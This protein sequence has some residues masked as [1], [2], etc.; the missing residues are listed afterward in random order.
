MALL[1]LALLAGPVFGSTELSFSGFSGL[2]SEADLGEEKTFSLALDFREAESRLFHH[3]SCAA[4]VRC[5]Q[6]PEE[7]HLPYPLS[8]GGIVIPSITLDMVEASGHEFREV[9]GVVGVSRTSAFMENFPVISLNQPESDPSKV[10]LSTTEFHASGEHLRVLVTGNDWSFR[11]GFFL[12]DSPITESIQVVFDPSVDTLRVPHVLRPLFRVR[13]SE[14]YGTDWK[15]FPGDI[16]VPC[17]SAGEADIRFDMSLQPEGSSDRIRI[18]PELLAY[19]ADPQNNTSWLRRNVGGSVCRFRVEFSADIHDQIIIGRQ[20]IS[21]ADRVVLDASVPEIRFFKLTSDNRRGVLPNPVALIPVFSSPAVVVKQNPI[22]L[23]LDFNRVGLDP[24][25]NGSQLILGSTTPRPFENLR[26]TGFVYSFI[27]LG[28]SLIPAQSARVGTST[29]SLPI[30]PGLREDGKLWSFWLEPSA[31]EYAVILNESPEG[32]DIYLARNKARISM[33]ELDL[34]QPR[35]RAAAETAPPAAE[36]MEAETS[37][38]PVDVV[39][40]ICF[41]EIGMQQLVQDIR[42]CGHMF[43]FECIRHWLEFKKQ[44]C[45]YC[46][47]SVKARPPGSHKPA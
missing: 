13:L 19:E 7:D 8:L 30:A 3:G 10:I 37:P 25:I 15:A 31:N 34:P 1:L 36:P 46:R 12:N 27:R 21:A 40:A 33:A 18:A 16:F 41:E 9:T 22:R 24:R 14:I 5:V 28:P 42:P 29:F 38:A 35:L 17:T 23:S 43:H 6:P 26:Q 45:P 2:V 4:F 47:G 20:F 39:C 32:I 44:D 11:S